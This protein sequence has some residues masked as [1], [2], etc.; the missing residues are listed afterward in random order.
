MPARRLKRFLDD[1]GVKYVS[2]SHSPAFTAQEIAA[3]A[4]IPGQELAKTVMIRLDGKMAMAILPASSL[5]DLDLLADAAGARRAEIATEHEFKSLFPGCEPGAMPP[6]GNLYD[7]DV[8]SCSSL[9]DDEE[10]AFN[11]GSHTELVKLAYR[12]FERLVEPSVAFFST[13]RQP[14]TV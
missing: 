10:I 14:A 7:L 2:I 4:H 5:V 8:F 11:A 12:D 13:R 3:T 9:S 6:F 1:N